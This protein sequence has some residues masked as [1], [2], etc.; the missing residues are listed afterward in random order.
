[1]KDLPSRRIRLMSEF[2]LPLDTSLYFIT[3]QSVMKNMIESALQ[4]H[5][6]LDFRALDRIVPKMS[7]ITNAK[8]IRLESWSNLS[9]FWFQTQRS[10]THASCF[11]TSIHPTRPMVRGLIL[12]PI[13]S[14]PKRTWR[15]IE[16][17]PG[18]SKHPL[19]NQHWIST[20]LWENAK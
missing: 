14:C 13:W 5:W 19:L 10:D 18:I 9:T 2:A 15:Q 7:S 3:R 16:T 12:H 6:R 1:M 17:R 11:P 4:Y 8:R 20:M